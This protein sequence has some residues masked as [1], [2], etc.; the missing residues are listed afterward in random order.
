MQI[1]Y[2]VMY[3]YQCWETKSM[4]AII[5]VY[6]IEKISYPNCTKRFRKHALF[7]YIHI[8]KYIYNICIMP[9]SLRIICFLENAFN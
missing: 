2:F 6:V 9:L 7:L 1:E 3:I 4:L 8:I 5:C